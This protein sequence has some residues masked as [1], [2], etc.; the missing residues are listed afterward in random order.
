VRDVGDEAR[1][2]GD[3]VRDVGD[4]V[5]DVGDEEWASRLAWGP[6]ALS[7][8]TSGEGVRQGFNESFKDSMS[9]EFLRAHQ[10]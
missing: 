7:V 2:V 3:E 4:E 10:Q 8:G 5:R 9:G 1:D 6:N